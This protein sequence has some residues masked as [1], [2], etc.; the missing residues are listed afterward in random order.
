MKSFRGMAGSDMF[1]SAMNI[2]G[3]EPV[4]YFGDVTYPPGGTFGPKMQPNLHLLYFYSG[5]AVITVAGSPFSVKAGEMI[6]M[7]HDTK[8]FYQF[9]EQEPTRH[10]WCSLLN[11]RLDKGTEAAFRRPPAIVPF[12]PAMGQLAEMGW[13]M[14]NPITPAELRLRESIGIALMNM[15]LL[16]SNF[17]HEDKEPMPESVSKVKLLIDT[18]YADPLTLEEMAGTACMSKAHLIRLFSKYLKYSPVAYLWHLRVTH[19]IMLIQSTGLPISEIAE[20]SGFKNIYHF[21]RRIAASTGM[22]PSKLRRRH[23]NG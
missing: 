16:A 20:K 4:F 6:L 5:S 14:R 15:A 10:G 23:W 8:N 22:P 13:K 12:T 11:P 2:F 17:L 18:H 1:L 9:S 3:V 21:S 7:P 19:G